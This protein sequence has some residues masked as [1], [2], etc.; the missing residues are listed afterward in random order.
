[1]TDI[2]WA[3]GILNMDVAAIVFQFRDITLMA[4]KAQFF[5]L[6]PGGYV[7]FMRDR[8]MAFFTLFD[9]KDRMAVRTEKPLVLRTMA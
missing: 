9:Q 5:T 4:V 8:I 2:T 6:H 1:M 3:F 7:P